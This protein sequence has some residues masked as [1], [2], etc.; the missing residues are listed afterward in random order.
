MFWEVWE[1]GHHA[2]AGTI[3][4]PLSCAGCYVKMGKIKGAGV[5]PKGAQ[6]VRSW[7]G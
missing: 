1:P 3:L 2:L 5:V 4:E 6:L 7:T